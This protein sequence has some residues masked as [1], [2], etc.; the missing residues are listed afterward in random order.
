MK[1]KRKKGKTKIEKNASG[2]TTPF[3]SHSPP[4]LEHPR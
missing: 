4:G 3:A 1:K 2:K